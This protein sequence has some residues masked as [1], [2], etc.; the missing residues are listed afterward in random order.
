MHT[1]TRR[2]I[3][4]TLPLA[5]IVSP[6][7]ARAQDA[8]PSRAVRMIIPWPPGGGVDVF[9]RVIQAALGTQLG[10][11]V[12]I[13]NIGG[14]S[15]RVGTLSASRAAPDGY[16][17][18]LVNDTFA[19]TEALPSGGSPQLRSAFIPV[20]LAASGPQGVLTHPKSGIKTIQDF[21]TAAAE[22]PGKLN[23]GVPGLGSSQHL[24]SELLLRAAGNLRVTHVPYRGG[25]PV[26]QDLISGNIDAAVVTFAAAAQQVR[27][28]QLIGLAVTS[29][30]RPAAFP[31]VPTAA[32]TVAPGFV[33]T[34]WLG[35]FAPK[36]TPAAAQARLHGAVLGALKDPA[37]VTRLR[38]LGFDPIGLD[39]SAFGQLFDRTI[40]TFESIATERGLVA[41]D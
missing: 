41:G 29:A 4:S 26:L 8:Y 18:V 19:A 23:V 2:K 14:S 35:M 39:G 30:T 5:A 24:A 12:V 20:T 3:I 28:G 36:G 34:T 25:G 37:V 11:A 27:A 13:E 17:F 6:A 15:G 7:V 22:Q 33:Q 10:Q 32:E 9:G 31:D 1:I 40:A 16:T 38:E 21:V